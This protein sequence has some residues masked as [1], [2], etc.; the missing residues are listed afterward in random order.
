M[1]LPLTESSQRF[2]LHNNQGLQQLRRTHEAYECRLRRRGKDRR[3]A[4]V[5]LGTRGIRV[6]RSDAGPAHSALISDHD[7]IT[8]AAIC[9]GQRAVTGLVRNLERWRA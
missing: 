7:T 1:L 5:R 6:A 2:C 9:R 8:Q 4:A 3:C